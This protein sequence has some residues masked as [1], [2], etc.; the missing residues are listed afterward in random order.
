MFDEQS[1]HVWHLIRACFSVMCSHFG[2]SDG[3][4]A[5]GIVNGYG[6]FLGCARFKCV[7]LC[8]L[9]IFDFEI[10]AYMEK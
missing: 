6:S 3:K 9:F 1:C 7:P 10:P 4:T 2:G 8:T 5:G